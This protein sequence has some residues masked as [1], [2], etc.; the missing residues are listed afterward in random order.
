[1]NDSITS[2]PRPRLAARA[3]SRFARWQRRISAR[4]QA[5]DDFA[6]QAGWTITR[7]RFGGRIYRDPRF[8]Q[9]T[10]ARAPG[11]SHQVAPPA[12]GP[13]AADNRALTDI[14]HRRAASGPAREAEPERRNQ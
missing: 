13:P 8:D 14:R 9:L 10:A 12:V 4:M 6:R 7:T 2:L 11:T 1:M 3:I 5:G